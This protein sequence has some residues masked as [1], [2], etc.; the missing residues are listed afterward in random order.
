MCQVGLEATETRKMTVAT[1]GVFDGVHLGHRLLLERTVE[2]ARERGAESVVFTL[3]PHPRTLFQDGARE[4]RLLTSEGERRELLRSLGVGRVETLPFTHALAALRAKEYLAM[5]RERYGVGCLV[6]GH[7]N[8]IGS[9]LCSAV[10]LAGL[11][12]VEVV[13]CPAVS[14]EG[15]PVS[16]TR[17]RRA[18][19]EG[20]LALALAM[21]GHPYTLDGIVVAGTRTGRTIGYP[22]ANL[23]CADPL[24]LLPA[25]GV[26]A[27]EVEVHGDGFRGMCNIGVRPTVGGTYR[28]VETHILDFSEDIY[29]F[30]LR[31]SFLRRLRDERKFAS[32]GELRLQLGRDAL[33]CRD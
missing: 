17:I 12:D 15:R 8:R 1:T 22:T 9:D 21:L 5:L 23:Q 2:L 18:L 14:V 19:G 28:T 32:L 11:P 25:D 29:G 13:S 16:S 7:D 3:S 20:N 4:L 33:A 31:L 10:S 24:K 6:M 26:Y 30:P 27:V